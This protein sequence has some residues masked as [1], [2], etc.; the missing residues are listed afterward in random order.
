[1]CD[2]QNNHLLKLKEEASVA[3]LQEEAYYIQ[4]HN[5]YPAIKDLGDK[6]LNEDRFTYELTNLTLTNNQLVDYTKTLGTLVTNNISYL[7]LI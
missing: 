2:I 4:L 6:K 3:K 7:T 1:M 5:L